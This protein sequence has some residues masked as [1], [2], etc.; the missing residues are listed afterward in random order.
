MAT[1]LA[2]TEVW[3]AGASAVTALAWWVDKRAARYGRRRIPERR[4]LL[5]ALLGGW[6]AALLMTGLLRHKTRKQPFAALLWLCALLNAATVAA[7]LA[8]G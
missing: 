1:A 3:M 7:L 8:R 5:L 2:A 6:P 4:L